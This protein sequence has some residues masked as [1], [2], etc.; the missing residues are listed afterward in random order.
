MPWV[1]CP[2]CRFRQMTTER[3]QR[4]GETLAP[5]AAPSEATPTPPPGRATSRNARWLAA[6]A[7]AAMLLVFL[8]LGR[9]GRPPASVARKAAP[10]PTAG[11]LDLSGRWQ[12][13]LSKMAGANPP[14]PVLK[15]IWIE[16]SLDGGILAA[17]VVFT[18]PG[19]GGAGAGYRIVSD[20]ARR[21]AE[22]APSFATE[23]KG[24]PLPTDFLQLP[25]WV[26]ERARLWRAL[27]GAGGGGEPARYLLVESLETDYLVQAGINESGF[28]SYAFFSP[29]YAPARGSDVLSRI[30]HP[31][32]GASL[33]GFQNLV[34]DLSGA[35]D[36]LELR[37]PVTISGPEGGAPDRITLTR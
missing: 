6:L 7:G 27:E 22:A 16:S 33:R 8:W 1:V 13:Q 10:V 25:G 2:R 31:E 20:G 29:A 12:A 23:P 19:R 26:P 24:A 11:P 37:L 21:L 5:P 9:S 35:A 15:E 3:C 34:W 36:F 4:C 18:D 17:R 14:H 30:I 32:P 28:L